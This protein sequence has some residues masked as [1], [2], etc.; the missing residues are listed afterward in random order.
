MAKQDSPS[1]RLIE[2]DAALQPSAGMPIPDPTFTKGGVCV[3]GWLAGPNDVSPQRVTSGGANTERSTP[4]SE[5][6]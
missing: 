3:M 6:G 4:Y 5:K 1:R 2:D